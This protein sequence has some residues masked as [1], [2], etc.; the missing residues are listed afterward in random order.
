M[1]TNQQ[2]RPFINMMTFGHSVLLKVILN[3]NY[4]LS[5]MLDYSL[6]FE[7]GLQVWS[8]GLVEF[9]LEVE[10]SLMNTLAA[11]IR[12]IIVEFHS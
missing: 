9:I 11:G 4:R 8:S 5:E 2:I 3:Y 1:V 7:S 6:V 12:L 10:L